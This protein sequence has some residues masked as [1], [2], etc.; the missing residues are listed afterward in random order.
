MTGGL[1]RAPTAA[2]FGS[3]GLV[4]E[5]V[6]RGT[7][8]EQTRLRELVAGRRAP[9]AADGLAMHRIIHK[10]GWRTCPSLVVGSAS[11]GKGPRAGQGERRTRAS[12]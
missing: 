1:G 5:I 2:V 10:P 8:P 3:F 11:G 7:S 4:K 12:R 6:G 9:R